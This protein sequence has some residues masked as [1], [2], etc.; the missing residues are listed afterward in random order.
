MPGPRDPRT[1]V[2]H[3]ISRLMFKTVLSGDLPNAKKTVR[4][5][6]T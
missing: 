3:E 5:L 6:A 2:G 1:D 4:R